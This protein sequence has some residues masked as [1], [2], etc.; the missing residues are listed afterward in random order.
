MNAI[1]A[2]TSLKL[3][4]TL[5]IKS[6]HLRKQKTANSDLRDVS[7]QFE[8]SPYFHW[9]PLECN[10]VE[11]CKIVASCKSQMLCSRVN[12]LYDPLSLFQTMFKIYTRNEIL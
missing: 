4:F 10:L 11:K 7:P 3:L 5:Q 12:A 6:L 1:I 9:R 2:R 8:L